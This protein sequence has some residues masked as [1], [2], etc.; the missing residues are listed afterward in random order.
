MAEVLS[1][2][3]RHLALIISGL[4]LVLSAIMVRLTN[5]R[6]DEDRKDRSE[7]ERKSQ[8]A[9]RMIVLSFY[10]HEGETVVLRVSF[11]NESALGDGVRSIEVVFGGTTVRFQGAIVHSMGVPRS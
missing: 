2:I 9:M 6:L 11:F 7:K 8:P 4:A 10:R 1:E 3:L 5:K